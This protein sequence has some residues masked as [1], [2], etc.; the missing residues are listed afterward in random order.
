MINAPKNRK[1]YIL[2]GLALFLS[3]LL[4][5]TDPIGY[6]TVYAEGEP[7]SESEA[8]VCS[9]EELEKPTAET[10]ITTEAEDEITTEESIEELI[11][12]ESKEGITT[13]EP[14]EELMTEGSE[15]G[16]TTEEPKEDKKIDYT[17]EAASNHL[18]DTDASSMAS[19]PANNKFDL[20][21]GDIQIND[22]PSSG[23]LSVVYGSK[24]KVIYGS[25]RITIT[26]E[27]VAAG[28]NI[29]VNAKSEQVNLELLDAN[30]VTTKKSGMSLVSGSVTNLTIS[31]S[32]TVKMKGNHIAAMFVPIGAKLTIVG[33]GTLE[34][35]ADTY[36]DP[37][38]HTGYSA[39]AAIG[40]MNSTERSKADS[41]TIIIMSGTI[42]AEGDGGAGIGGGAGGIASNITITGGTVV[43][44]GKL[45][46]AAIGSGS[47][48]QTTDN[49]TSE[50]NITI[51]GGNVTAYSLTDAAAIGGGWHISGGNIT[52][53]G[54]IVTVPES[55]GKNAIGAGAE[56]RPGGVDKFSTGGDGSGTG[57]GNAVILLASRLNGEGGFISDTSNRAQ[58]GG[59][60]FLASEGLVYSKPNITESFSIPAGYNLTVNAGQSVSN[61]NGIT[62]TVDGSIINRGEILGNAKF[63]INKGQIENFGTIKNSG[64]VQISSDGKIYNGSD[65][66]RGKA[67]IYNLA[68]STVEVDGNIYNY[69]KMV[70]EDTA[71]INGS[72]NIYNLSSVAVEVTKNGV[73]IGESNPVRYGD[74]ITIQMQVGP[75][76]YTT[77][78]EWMPVPVE[79][80][81]KLWDGDEV[82][83]LGTLQTQQRQTDGIVIF[84]QTVTVERTDGVLWEGGKELK[85][86]ATMNQVGG[87]QGYLP[88]S[89][90]ETVQ[91]DKLPIDMSMAKW[92]SNSHIY[93][94]SQKT[95]EITGLPNGVTATYTGNEQTEPGSYNAMPALEYDIYNHEL[96]NMPEAV[97]ESL[98][99]GYP[100]TIEKAV[101][102]VTVWPVAS[103]LTDGQLLS[104]S[105]LT[106]GTVSV[107]GTFAW[108][109]PGQTVEWKE[110]QAK[111]EFESV[112]TP[113][114]TIHYASVTGT[115]SVK[116]NPLYYTVAFNPNGGDFTGD[117]VISVQKGK[118]IPKPVPPTYVGASFA[119][120]YKEESL[121]TL[122][123]FDVDQVI[124]DMTLYA[125]YTMEDPVMLVAIPAEVQL[126]NNPTTNMGEG[127]GTIKVQTITDPHIGYPDKTLTIKADSKVT[128]IGNSKG[129]ICK[130]QVYNEDGSEYSGNKP[131]MSFSFEGNQTSTVEHSFALKIPMDFEKP[132]DTYQGNMQFQLELN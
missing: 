92:S 85:V 20:R 76:P 28:N 96:T 71:Q 52:I 104:A 62:V 129:A 111:Q 3:I 2:R 8:Q 73:P 45:R 78:P 67:E 31:S 66:D 55:K 126:V 37:T 19:D 32:N 108:K 30:I 26:T 13:E 117:K 35:T 105:V 114:D 77:F 98:A 34:V 63:L 36:I 123:D 99:N 1:K 6:R 125:K 5:L 118:K 101:P 72:G 132:E 103:E 41:G 51:T 110:N 18:A 33:S 113:S 89:A 14:I 106:G 9:G 29:V 57:Y 38:T 44:K 120:W 75:G 86:G 17:N 82:S 127:N 116:V 102:V 54:G 88:D 56:E 22:G 64:N 87:L 49:R 48:A 130:V 68:G 43:A 131:L 50:Q 12:E 53:T 70:K 65:S 16:I 39:G 10:S 11:T 100:W 83:S 90:S 94:G 91:Y 21:D 95:V 128:L 109:D 81:F 80:Q 119:G 58:W 124:G 74:Q 93:N 42:M 69:A 27:G 122:W 15:E 61:D 115:M 40:G 47:G 107:S 25:D 121:T 23:Q 79:V 84:T 7:P 59:I 46:S 112:F 4:L 24:S 97:E 60:I